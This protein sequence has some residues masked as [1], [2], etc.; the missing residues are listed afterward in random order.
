[1]IDIAIRNK[2]EGSFKFRTCIVL[3]HKDKILL[4]KMN[5]ND[6]YC[7]PGG[8][9]ELGE[10]TINGTIREAKEELEIDVKVE[11]LI[12]IH[13]NFFNRE[14]GKIFHELGYYYLCSAVD[15]SQ[16][17]TEDYTFIEHDKGYINKLE[18]KWVTKEEFEKTPFR[19]QI[20][21]QYLFDTK[22]EINYIIGN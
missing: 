20:I 1:M 16:L 10:S 21:K 9:I 12:A 15:E 3:M 22:K 11:R 18:F 5:D 2:E 13:E 6:F 17:K 19:P 8:H 4:C 14:D 7:L